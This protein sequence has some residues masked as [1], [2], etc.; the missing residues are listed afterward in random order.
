[1]SGSARTTRATSVVT[2]G[3]GLG[4]RRTRDRDAS[5]RDQLG[6]V[7]ARPRQAAPDELGIEPEASRRHRSGRLARMLAGP[8]VRLRVEG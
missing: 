5:V 1:M 4:R 8:I 7:V 2:A 6:G 3:G